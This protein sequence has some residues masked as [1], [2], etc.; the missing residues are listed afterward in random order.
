MAGSTL[1]V[2]HASTSSSFDGLMCSLYTS[3]S[4]TTTTTTFITDPL[5]PISS[6]LHII[7]VC[8]YRVSLNGHHIVLFLNSR[9]MRSSAKFWSRFYEKGSTLE[10]GTQGLQLTQTA[11][12]TTHVHNFLSVSYKINSHQLAFVSFVTYQT[13]SLDNFRRHTELR[14]IIEWI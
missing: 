2:F 14:R 11:F 8:T 6:Y 9:A 12:L 3:C 13:L 1:L 10:F 4:C 7:A 5:S